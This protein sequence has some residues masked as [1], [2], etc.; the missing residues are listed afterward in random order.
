M[1]DAPRK[2]PNSTPSSVLIPYDENPEYRR[3][4]LI[5]YLG[6]KRH[7][8]DFIYEGIEHVFNRLGKRHLI[9]FD[10]FSGSGVVARFL[11]PYSQHL[12]VNDMEKYSSV[13]N[14]CYLAN[15]SDYPQDEVVYWNNW[16]LRNAEEKPVS[17][18]IIATH[19]APR[20]DEDIQKNERVF[21][22]RRNAVFLDSVRHYIGGAPRHIQDFLLAPLLSEA[23]V[24]VNTAGVFKGFYKNQK[25][26]IGQF[27]GG[28][29]IS[30]SR[31]KGDIKL[32]LPVLSNYE[33]ESTVL[34]GDSN[35]IARSLFDIDLAYVDPPYNQHPYGSNYFMLNLLVN[36][37]L[38]APLSKVAGIP[39][40]WNRSAY[41]RSG[42]SR[43]SLRDIVE[44][45]NAKFLLISFNSEGFIS[46]E[47]MQDLLKGYGSLKCW[48]Q[49]YNTFRGSRNLGKRSLHVNEYL[50]L[51]EKK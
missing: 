12:Y 15:K 6:N 19:Y 16:V 42:T 43:D 47:Q 41:N 34:N 4:Q 32:P 36:N 45:L 20:N 40:D 25:T 38:T 44:N 46:H 10:V 7:L 37:M 8:L 3:E 30:L 26:G 22:T 5:T 11:K 31:I 1:S 9:T 39:K 21:Y 35:V 23:S 29:E 33:C 27:G 13:I 24:H 2:T 50:Y 18:G 48:K 17:D 28:Q 49:S 14:R 51:L